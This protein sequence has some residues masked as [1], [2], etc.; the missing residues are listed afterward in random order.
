VF[1]RRRKPDSQ[2]HTGSLRIPI[3]G[4]GLD[5]WRTVRRWTS[6]P[7]WGRRLLRSQVIPEDEQDG[8]ILIQIDG[9]SR[10]QLERAL[11]AGR[12]PFL[13]RVLASEGY[14]LVTQYSGL[15]STTS[16]VQAELFYG[17]RGAVP[18]HGFGDRATG[19]IVTM[20]NAEKAEKVE[21]RISRSNPG[22][23][24]GGSAY[25]NIYTGGASEPHFC[26]SDMG[27]GDLFHGA[28]LWR[29]AAFVLLNFGSLIRI[30]GL[31]L[32]QL[33]V[34]V[35][36]VVRGLSNFKECLQE[37][38]F[39]PK[40]IGVAVVLRE[41]ITISAAVDAARGLPVVQLNFLGYDEHSHHRGPD[42]RFAQWSLRGIDRCIRKVW[43][44][45]ERSERRHY[46]IWVY[47]DHGQHQVTPYDV[48]TG[49]LIQDV[50]KE[51]FQP[52]YDE[53]LTEKH[54]S[55]DS[56][57]GR[58]R[59]LRRPPKPSA[60]TESSDESDDLTHRILVAAIGPLGHIYLPTPL[61]EEQMASGCQRLATDG[62]VPLVL[63]PTQEGTLRAWT[64]DG[65]YELPRDAAKVFGADHPFLEAIGADLVAVARNPD[66]GDILFTGWRVG[67]KP[68]SYV[69][70]KGAHGAVAPEECQAFVLLPVGT[71]FEH[72]A[73]DFSRPDEFL[74][75][76]MHARGQ[77]SETPL[78]RR[79]RVAQDTLRVMTYN[80]HSCM[81]LDGRLSISRI[82]RVIA[83][84]DADVIALQELDA[85]RPRSG[86]RDQAQELA[87]QLGMN[88][89]FHP[90]LSIASE[91]YGDAIL[92]RLPM[93]L[94][95]AAG[96]P[97]R[98][99]I[100]GSE[101]RGAVWVEVEMGERKIQI[102]NTHLGLRPQER[103]E[104][105]ESLLGPDWLGHPD[106]QSPVIFCGD[107]NAGPRSSVYRS[108]CARLRDTQLSVNGNRP[109]NTWL[110]TWPVLRLDH[111]FVSDGVKVSSAQV[112]RG[113]LVQVASDHLPVVVDVR[114]GEE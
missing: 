80:V 68:L 66:S 1:R 70:E 92:S 56:R 54:E 11:R 38:K 109:I 62:Q 23:L 93:R 99:L 45:A 34:A 30:A 71:P 65:E 106:C 32:L 111:I 112:P 59:L 73:A 40:R 9:L 25:S 47:S 42:S 16:A 57:Y 88:V 69:Y 108:I 100:R 26:A 102:L 86:T 7:E 63:L 76:A 29:I 44:A 75:A 98:T 21:Q 39:I 10:K 55:H 105:I 84:C 87:R 64:A 19:Q 79:R 6:R 90:A 22:L 103:Q 53:P 97:V 114:L 110:S 28:R 91:A 104:Q 12:M 101:P 95:R 51:V 27:W 36:D 83:Q 94:K 49:R 96:L 48:A 50:V 113:S 74:A 13:K 4:S 85:H 77:A 5:K 52:F 72:R 33:L 24:A 37:I 81:G 18:S 31:S 46:Q 61:T 43:R 58:S 14:E 20:L 41:V 60:N 78:R 35:T 17:A 89:H 15:P 8:L 3:I 107:F 82:A 67:T 2:P